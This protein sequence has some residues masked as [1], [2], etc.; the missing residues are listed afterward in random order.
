MPQLAKLQKD[1]IAG[2][3]RSAPEVLSALKTQGALTPEQRMQIY[4]NNTFLILTDNLKATFSATA[5]LGSENFFKFLAHEFIKAHPPEAGDMNGYGA[6]LPSFMKQSGLVKDHPFLADVAAVEWLRQESYMAADLGKGMTDPSLRLFSSEWP[7]LKLWQ[8]AKGLIP[9]SD[10]SFAGGGENVI[11]FRRDDG[12]EMWSVDRP[13][14]EFLRSIVEVTPFD[15]PHGF[16]APYHL[17]RF[18]QAGI[19]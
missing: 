8:L 14:F 2:V 18:K 3:L 7:V 11:L 16:D 19:L 15:A 12:V 1:F 17:T 4:R 13:V 9:L 5:A 10:V 6:K